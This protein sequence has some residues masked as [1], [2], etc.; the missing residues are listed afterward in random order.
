MFNNG[1]FAKGET[2]G[3]LKRFLLFLF[4]L[5]GLLCV[6]IL[7]IPWFGYGFYQIT[8]L[9]YYDAFWIFLEVILAM[10]VCFLVFNIGRALFSRKHDDTVQVMSL[11][12][13]EITVTKSAVASQ[14]T[15]IV[16]ALGLGTTKDVSVNPVK[17]GTVS[18]D[19][20]VI[21]QDSIDITAEA[22][23]LHE[24]LVTGLK[25]MCGEKLGNVSIEFLE[26]K[27]GSSLVVPATDE[28]ESQEP[29]YEGPA[30][31]NQPVQETSDPETTSEVAPDATGDITIPM[32]TE[33][34]E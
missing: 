26:P 32:R 11:D 14:V 28:P 24:A 20:K 12:G 34:S 3:G 30:E 8:D 23:I 4:S 18:V 15:H 17:G 1:V 27:H 25:A 10:T 5:A 29:A 33:K 22:P 6:G 13:G 31:V 9:L 19:A 21:P 16:E 2:M 7:G